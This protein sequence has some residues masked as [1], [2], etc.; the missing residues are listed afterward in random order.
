MGRSKLRIMKAYF[1]L[2]RLVAQVKEMIPKNT[3]L[4]IVSDHGVEAGGHHSPKAFYSFNIDP[5][6][7]PRRIK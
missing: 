3:L 4:M 6:W 1:E 2:D 7:K 5:E